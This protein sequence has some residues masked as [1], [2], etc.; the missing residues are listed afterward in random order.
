MNITYNRYI[1]DG[2]NQQQ[3]VRLYFKIRNQKNKD[4]MMAFCVSKDGNE[5]EPTSEDPRKINMAVTV[6]CMGEREARIE[7]K[8]F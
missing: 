1:G 3:Q 7:G 5:P 6:F 2:C 8:I 4:W